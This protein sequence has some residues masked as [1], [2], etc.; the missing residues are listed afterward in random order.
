MSR[1][2][3]YPCRVRVRSRPCAASNGYRFE[4]V[5][6]PGTKLE[7][8]PAPVATHAEATAGDGGGSRWRVPPRFRPALWL[9]IAVEVVSRWLGRPSLSQGALRPRLALS[10]REA[11]ARRRR[12][13]RPRPPAHGRI[14]RGARP[15]AQ[16]ASVVGA[17]KGMSSAVTTSGAFPKPLSANRFAASIR[18][19]FLAR[20]SSSPRA[21][22]QRSPHRP[23]PRALARDG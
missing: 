18:S 3:I 23:R 15:R 19:A 13:C 7:R 17:G 2:W 5:M 14:R 9:L 10:A 6:K 16:P 1:D 8:K 4:H 22:I 21:C 12:C 20:S 11:E